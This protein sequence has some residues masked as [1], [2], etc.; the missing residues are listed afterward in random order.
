MDVVWSHA[1]RF[2]PCVPKRVME[3]PVQM[4]CK[5][6]AA[7]RI[8]KDLAP[9]LSDLGWVLEVKIMRVHMEPYLRLK[10]YEN[11]IDTEK[12][13]SMIMS[14][15]ELYGLEERKKAHSRLAEI[16]E[17][18]YRVLTGQGE[19]TNGKWGWAK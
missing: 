11:R 2:R 1:A 19:E 17:E 16:N 7:H 12:W 13:R 10:G 9:P 3:C 14:F 5:F 8:M 4:Y 6:V 15:S 18:R